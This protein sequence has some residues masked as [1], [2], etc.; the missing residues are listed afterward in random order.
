[1]EMVDRVMLADLML[2]AHSRILDRPVEEQAQ[3]LAVVQ[4]ALT[5]LGTPWHHQA[6]V[7]GAGVDCGMFLAEVFEACGILPH[8]EPGDYPQDWG[9]H[10]DDERFLAQVE[11]FAKP[12]KDP[13]PGDIVLYRFG[14][15]MSHAGLVTAWPQMIHSYLDHGVPHGVVLEDAEANQSLAPRFMGAWSP[16]GG[17]R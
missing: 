8:I 12:V 10:R 14:R 6:R 5:W 9:Q 13:L 11:Q 4:E 1:M 16:W 2:E 7:K 15:C 17:D 3:R